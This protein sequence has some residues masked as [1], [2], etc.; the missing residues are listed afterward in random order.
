MLMLKQIRLSGFGGQGVILAGSLL[1]HAAI[2]EGKWVSG[3]NAYGAQARGGK[4]T[5]EVVISS[6]KIS[7]PHIITTDLL[8]AFSQSAYNLYKTDLES[9]QTM[10]VYDNLLVK[11]DHGQKI[12]QV[13]IQSTELALQ[14]F[15]DKQ[16]ANIILLAA[17]AALGEIVS[18]EA[19]EKTINTKVDKRY[20]ELNL[21]AL[22][23]GYNLGEEIQSGRNR[24]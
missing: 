10:V 11:V 12:E 6:Q 14:H 1:G 21:K 16:T 4:A 5:S 2:A 15:K 3:S 9:E 19:L 22:T 17:A 8:I 23:L 13:G 7:F 18:K 24:S 20:I